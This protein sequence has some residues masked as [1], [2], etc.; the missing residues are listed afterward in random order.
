MLFGELPPKTVAVQVLKS[1]E[2]RLLGKCLPR[3]WMW[4]EVSSARKD[5]PAHTRWRAQ[6]APCEA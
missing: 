3:P 5:Q 2:V 6:A 4:L 1:G